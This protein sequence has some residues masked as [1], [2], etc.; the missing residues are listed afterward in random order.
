M[1]ESEVLYIDQ[2]K[3]KMYNITETNRSQNS[4]LIG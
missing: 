2:E 3:P 4:M 1:F